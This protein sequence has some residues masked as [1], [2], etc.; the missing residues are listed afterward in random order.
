[1][2]RGSYRKVTVKLWKLFRIGIITCEAIGRDLYAKT[3]ANKFH[4]QV[5]NV[6]GGVFSVYD[7]DVVS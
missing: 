4:A 5:S 1:M 7:V 6:F 3:G 2:Q